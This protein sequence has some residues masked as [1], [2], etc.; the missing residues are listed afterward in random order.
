MIIASV[1]IALI[2]A[3]ILFVSGLAFLA[4]GAVTSSVGY[5]KAT[6]STGTVFLFSSLGM[7]AFV[8]LFLALNPTGAY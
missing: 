3:M 6:R 5:G 4:I 7:I 2:V 8:L 1:V